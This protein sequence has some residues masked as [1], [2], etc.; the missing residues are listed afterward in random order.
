MPDQP[1]DFDTLVSPL[2]AADFLSRHW[3][4][5]HV[6][7]R[8]D[9]AS[10]YQS[11]ITAA[12]L[13]KLI[14][15][16][17]ARYPAIRLAKG[18]GYFPPEVYTRDVKHG[19]ESFL[20]VPDVKKIADEYRRGATVALPAIHRT[21]KPLGLLCDALQ[22]RFD[23]PA[24]ANV[25]ITPGNAAGFT[26]HYDVHEVFVLQIA[27]KKRWSIYSPVIALPHRSQL[28]TPNAYGGQSPLVE[29]ELHAGDLLYLPRGFLHS[30][31]TSDSFSAHVTVG[32]T[33]Y[34][35]VDLMKEFLA[36]AT[37][38]LQL[39]AALPVGFAHQPDAKP[40]LRQKML[41]ALDRLRA[42]A[43]L[44][45]LID[46][47]TARVRAAQVP[48]PAPFRVDESVIGPDSL[49]QMPATDT[50]RITQEG[51]KSLL[52]FD[53]VR[54]QL[55]A[56]VASTLK[57]MSALDQLRPKQLPDHLNLDE[58]LGLMRHLRDIGFLT[59]RGDAVPHDS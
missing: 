51:D 41:A 9:R 19:D 12:D 6:F 38:D 7:V 22:A 42:Q 26:P 50:Y 54:Y 57:A 3:E 53:G 40:L 52:E 56:P 17:D 47:F 25:Y 44:D 30:T 18:G 33:V 28:F 39:R 46:A 35:W 21:W 31:T 5:E 20:G 24:H 10:Y 27:G 55:P 16:S 11:L 45:H 1:F 32:I 34:T 43:D 49:L 59:V 8:R 48:R 58:R 36:S 2:S 15:D 29:V 14:S 23:H 4:R 37:D 13:E